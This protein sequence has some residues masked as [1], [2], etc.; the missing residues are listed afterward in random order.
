MEF[1]SSEYWE[2]EQRKQYE[3]QQEQRQYEEDM[4]SFYR[5]TDIAAEWL[6]GNV[7]ELEACNELYCMDTACKEEDLLQW[8]EIVLSTVVTKEEERN[9]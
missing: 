4:E 7:T 5:C 9:A 1:G 3:R 8:A 6:L 2:Q